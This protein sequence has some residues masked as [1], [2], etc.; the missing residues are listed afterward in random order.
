M[1]QLQFVKEFVVRR[2]DDQG[3]VINAF[4]ANNPKLK[5]H[6]MTSY[7]DDPF[8][9]ILVVFDREDLDEATIGDVT[10]LLGSTPSDAGLFEAAS[11]RKRG[12]G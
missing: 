1:R 6:T 3:E 12:E 2:F 9:H 7:L 4:L 10:T 5:I 8:V 11:S